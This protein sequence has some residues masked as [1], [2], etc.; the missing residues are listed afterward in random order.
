[1]KRDSVAL[2]AMQPY[3]SAEGRG[4]VT[5]R[6]TA[7]ITQEDGWY[8]AHCL[9]LGGVSQGRTIGEA[10]AN[11]SE[12]VELYIESFATEELPES[13]GDVMLCSLQVAA[14]A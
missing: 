4:H 1:V 14:G 7:G 6:Y 2:L 5:R 9:E 10:R 13:A 12:A 11:L 8:V 3:T